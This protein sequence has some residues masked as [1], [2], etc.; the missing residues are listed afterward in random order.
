[1]NRSTFVIFAFLSSCIEVTTYFPDPKVFPIAD[2]F[3]SGKVQ[4]QKLTSTLGFK[5]L[6]KDSAGNTIDQTIFKYAPYQFDT[7]DVD[8]DGRTE[9]LIGLI[10]STKFDPEEKKDF[11]F[12]ALTADS[13]DRFGWVLRYVRN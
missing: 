11:S 5:V 9:I 13:Y 2:K 7:A 3:F 1:M 6:L 10:K 8:R 4:F 12:Y